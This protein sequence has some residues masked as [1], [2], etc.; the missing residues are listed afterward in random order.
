MRI[1]LIAKPGHENTG[2]GRYSIKLRAALQALGHEVLVVHPTVPL[3]GWLVRAVRRLL[4]WDLQAFFEN[5]PVWARYPSADVYHITS[6]NL[7]TLLFFQLSPIPTIV[8]V[9]DIIVTP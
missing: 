1:V 8:T 5:Y 9:H 3:P 6:Q 2:V 7:A 4:G